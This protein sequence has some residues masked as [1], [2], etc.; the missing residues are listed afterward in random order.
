MVD[1][2][3]R[4]GRFINRERKTRERKIGIQKVTHKMVLFKKT[5]E[6]KQKEMDSR[7]RG[8]KKNK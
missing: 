5:M 1:E 7:R 8:E 6:E 3:E 4:G 2:E